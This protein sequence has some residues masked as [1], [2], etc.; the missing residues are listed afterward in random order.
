MTTKQTYDSGTTFDPAL[1]MANDRAHVLQQEARNE[2][3][4]AHGRTDARPSA[5][6]RFGQALIDLGSAI[7]TQSGTRQPSPDRLTPMP[8][9]VLD[10]GADPIAERMIS[11]VETLKALSDPLRLRILEVMTAG[12]DETFTV[13]RLAA[14]L[15]HQ[16]DPALPPRQPAGRARA[17]RRRRS[18]SC[19]GSSRRAIGSASATSGSTGAC[20]RPTARPC[21]T[22]WRRLR[23]RPRRHRARAFAPASSTGRGRRPGHAAACSPEGWPASRRRGPP[24]SAHASSTLFDEFDEDPAASPDERCRL[25]P[26]PGVLSDDRS[27]DAPRTDR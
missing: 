21:T 5:R 16:P 27:A 12:A 6:I 10:L 8:D 14:I 9:D 13:K 7:A 26:R 24:R 25:R 22:R 1:A 3:L 20:C 23:H 2:R 19:P 15:G 11:D 18:G 4:A 17:D